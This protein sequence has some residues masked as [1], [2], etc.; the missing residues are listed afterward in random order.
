MGKNLQTQLPPVVFRA[1]VLEQESAAYTLGTYLSERDAIA[2]L[3]VARRQSNAACMEQIWFY[4]LRVENGVV[5]SRTDLNPTETG[6]IA[7]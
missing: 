4:T 2:R 1:C 6:Q 7:A 5:T 3:E